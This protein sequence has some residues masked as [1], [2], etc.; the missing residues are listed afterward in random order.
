MGIA[1]YLVDFVLR[2]NANERRIL[3]QTLPLFCFVQE[4]FHNIL[5]R[6]VQDGEPL[7]ITRKQA[8][9]TAVLGHPS[10]EIMTGDM[11]P[12]WVRRK[13]LGDSPS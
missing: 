1:L 9:S 3:S 13:S 8:R 7:S 4:Y 2:E 11:D 6:T 10:M 5:R 12:F